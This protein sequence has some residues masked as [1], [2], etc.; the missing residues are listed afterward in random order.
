MTARGP[1]DSLAKGSAGWPHHPAVTPREGE[2]VIEK[3]RSGAFRDADSMPGCGTPA[4]TGPSARAC[5]RRTASTRLP[6]RSSL[7]LPCDPD[8]RCTYDLPFARAVR[9]TDRRASQQDPW[10]RARESV[11]RGRGSIPAAGR[12]PAPAPGRQPR[13]IASSARGPHPDP[14][15]RRGRGSLPAWGDS[16]ARQAAF[17]RSFQLGRT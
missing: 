3:R 8:L 2:P 4:S 16:P 9:R 15:V 11:S 12:R 1:G 5:R 10:E 6:C 13:S 17:G 14:D 7:G